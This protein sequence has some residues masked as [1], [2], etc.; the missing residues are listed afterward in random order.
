MEYQEGIQ[1][2]QALQS[3]NAMELSCNTKEPFMEYHDGLW[4]ARRLSGNTKKL[5]CNMK[6]P[7]MEYQGAF[8]EY[9]I[10]K[11]LYQIP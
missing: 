1:E 11:K 4:N 9:Q 3:W 7:F 2:Y 5:L 8:M 6:K 10:T